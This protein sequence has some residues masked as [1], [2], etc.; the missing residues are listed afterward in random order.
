M[1]AARKKYSQ[2]EN[3]RAAQKRARQTE[4][5]KKRR[6]KY[7]AK[8]SISVCIASEIR[9]SLKGNKNGRHWEDVVGWSLQQ[10]KRRFAQL[11]KKGM[12]W[13]NHGRVWEIDHINPVSAYNV[14]SID[15]TDFKRVWA[16]SN[17]QPLFKEENRS[18]SNKL[19]KHFQPTLF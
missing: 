19:E 14:T 11:F 1:I 15:C 6:K 4:A 16:L 18:K 13:D 5:T 2:S 12:T 9:Y 7:Y 10:F 17:L 8:N 3:G